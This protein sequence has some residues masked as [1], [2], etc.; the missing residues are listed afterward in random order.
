M[1]RPR[2]HRVLAAAFAAAS[3]MTLVDPQPAGAWHDEGHVYAAWA[4]VRALP[5]E[6]PAF[7]REGA[8]TIGHVSL[9]PDAFRTRDLPQLAAA[10][11]PMH[12]L[13]WELLR[14]RPLPEDRWKYTA[15]CAELGVDPGK[16]GLLP[17]AILE[18]TQRLAMAFAE[19]RRDPANPHVKTKAL[20]I[21]GE[22]AHYAADLHNPLHTTVDFDGRV[23]RPFPERGQP[24]SPRTGIHARVDALPSKL[25]YATFF[26]E[27][28]ETPRAHED[29]F[30]FVVEQMGASHALVD[31]VYE[32]E[33]SLPPTEVMAIDDPT[34]REFATERLRAAASFTASLYLTAWAMSADLEPPAWLHRELFEETFDPNAIPAPPRKE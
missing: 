23:P 32:L 21:A 15:L 20:V 17:Y 9:D 10:N 12:F 31:R 28:L 19:H 7:F 6:V 3:V 27:P 4:A 13:D 14:G 25:P 1:S 33:A 2:R 8:A 11:S 34:V 24:E 5:E 29:L 18:H 30:A 26:T 16:V 22:L